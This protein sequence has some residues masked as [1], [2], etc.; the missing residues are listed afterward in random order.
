MMASRDEIKRQL[1]YLNQ[2]PNDAVLYDAPAAGQRYATPSCA[3]QLGRCGPSTCGDADRDRLLELI[4]IAESHDANLERGL[5]ILAER[6][7][8]RSLLG[9]LQTG[10]NE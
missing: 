4:S 6:F 7:D 9:L 3:D 5:R 2:G 1:R 10:G 8:Y